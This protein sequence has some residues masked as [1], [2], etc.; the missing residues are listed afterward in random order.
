MNL[1]WI[2]RI[3]TGTLETPLI[4]TAIDA[5][6]DRPEVSQVRPPGP[7]SRV[8]VSEVTGAK[9]WI[10]VTESTDVG[11]D[12]VVL[13]DLARVAAQVCQRTVDIHL[14]TATDDEARAE[15][16]T[17]IIRVNGTECEMVARDVAFDAAADASSYGAMLDGLTEL[18]GEVP[19]RRSSEQVVYTRRPEGLSARLWRAVG[20]SRVATSTKV[21]DRPALGISI[22]HGDG[23]TEVIM[24]NES[25]RQAWM[26]HRLN[27]A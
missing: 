24:V 4:R 7:S 12:L 1:T 16:R 5:W 3:G 13:T 9:A 14:V 2:A 6:L 17:S 18:T 11:P 21:I 8:T 22:T 10:E 23:S 19:G 20:L 15:V 26:R 27:D 25:E